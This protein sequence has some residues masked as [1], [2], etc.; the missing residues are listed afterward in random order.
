MTKELSKIVKRDDAHPATSGVSYASILERFADDPAKLREVLAVRREWMADESAAAF[1]IAAVNFQQKVSIIPKL[2]MNNGRAYAK[3][4][5][6]WRAIRPLL[7]ECGLAV[8][9]ESVKTV[10]D[11]CT[12]DGHIRHSAGHAQPLHHEM[13]LPDSIPGQNKAQRAGSGETYAKRYALCAALGIQT[14][15]DNDGGGARGNPASADSV[16]HLRS[17]LAKAN[18]KED[19]VCTMLGINRLDDITEAEIK[20]VLSVLPKSMTAGQNA[21]GGGQSPDSGAQGAPG[22]ASRGELVKRLRKLRSDNPNIFLAACGDLDINPSKWDRSS[23]EKLA[24]LES[25]LQL[26]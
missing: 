26:A 19:P 16:K 18:R 9:W 5:R 12:L 8:T 22:E 24:A 17:E 25:A 1:N 3:M 15:E 21:G 7:D 10:N 14:G 2:D 13:P 11:V 6:I 23:D 20:R 4:D